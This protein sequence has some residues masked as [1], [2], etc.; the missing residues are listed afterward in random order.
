MTFEPNLTQRIVRKAKG[1]IAKD[2]RSRW[3]DYSTRIA[4]WGAL[5][6]GALLMVPADDLA[7]LPAN[8][9]AYVALV[10]FVLI[11]AAKLITEPGKG[12]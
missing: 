12:E 8:L 9:S 6:Q 4:K 10:M 5:V 3:N 2:W 1:R 11:G 7:R